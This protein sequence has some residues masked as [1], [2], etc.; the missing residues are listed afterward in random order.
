MTARL[1]YFLT[2]MLLVVGLPAWA[3]TPPCAKYSSEDDARFCLPSN[4]PVARYWEVRKDQADIEW[5]YTDEQNEDCESFES[6][7]VFVTI[8]DGRGKRLEFVDEALSLRSREIVKNLF[9]KVRFE[10]SAENARK[11]PVRFFFALPITC[12]TSR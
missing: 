4:V 3:E 5:I 7:R 8:E 11:E 2:F 1:R 9:K 6:I 10:P 12:P